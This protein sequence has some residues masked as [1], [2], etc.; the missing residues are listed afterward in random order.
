MTIPAILYLIYGE[1][2]PLRLAVGFLI[3]FAIIFAAGCLLKF[4]SEFF[5][6][7]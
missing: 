7:N 4:I 5:K 1:D 6:Q 2:Y 3:I